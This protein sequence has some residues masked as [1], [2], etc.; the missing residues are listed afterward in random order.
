MSCSASR[1]KRGSAARRAGAGAGAAASIIRTQE[2]NPDPEERAHEVPPD[3][4][5]ETQEAPPDPAE[6][7]REE[8]SDREEETLEAP[9][10]PEETK[11]TP[12]DPEVDT[13]E[14]PSDPE[15]IPR[16]TLEAS[17][18]PEEKTHVVPLDPEETQKTP[19]NPEEDTR[20]APPDPGVGTNDVAGLAARSTDLE[21]LVVPARRKLTIS[22]NLPP[23]NVIAHVE[24][25]A[26]RYG[27][28]RIAKFSA[29]EQGRRREEY[30][31]VRRW[32]LDDLQRKLEIPGLIARGTSPEQ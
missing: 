9:L 11:G 10:D 13:L 30:G 1:K 12:S 24:S 16:R 25:G 23:N 17:S 18:D 21:G 27:R 6:E 19:P 29:D 8:P 26:R 5:E 15:E 22:G 32:R 7:T 2:I 28:S 20:E 4:A 14:A 3:P 31:D